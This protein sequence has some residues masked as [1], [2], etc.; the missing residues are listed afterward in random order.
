MN[1]KQT[2]LMAMKSVRD[3]KVRALLT[4]LGIIVGVASVIT[5][6]SLVEGYQRDLVKQFEAFGTNVVNVSYHGNKKS[7]IDDFLKYSNEELSEYI[8]GISANASTYTQIKFKQKGTDSRVVFAD[9]NYSRV[10]DQTVTDGRDINIADIKNHSRVVV[11]GEAVRKEFFPAVSPIGK[12]MKI[13]GVNYTIIGVYKGKFGGEK[14][15]ADNMCTVPSTLGRKILG[16]NKITEYVVRTNNADDT[17]KYT[18]AITAYI[19]DN[20]F[21]AY[22]NDETLKQ[23]KEMTRAMSLIAG[24]IASVSLLVGGIG[25]MN[26]MFV[27]VTERTR[28]IGIRMAIGAK[29]K[30]IVLQFLIESATVSAI[31]GVIGIILGTLFALVGGALFLK[32]LYYPSLGLVIGSFTFSA[33]I[34]LIFGIFPANKASKLQPVDALRTQ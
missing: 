14:Y 9:E 10:N 6:V 25:I 18:D 31:G 21:S 32:N 2:I 26:I 3:S 30:D 19:N 29:R 22:S 28:E 7:I 33:S 24:A 34:G 4:T 13:K 11:I 15:S 20:A 23:I 16:T 5:L 12:T 8:A 1:F 17:K 27:T